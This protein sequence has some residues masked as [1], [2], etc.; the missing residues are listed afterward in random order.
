MM[1]LANEVVVVPNE[2]PV[3]VESSNDARPLNEQNG[4]DA[5]KNTTAAAQEQPSVGQGEG[6]GGEPLEQDKD[7]AASN[8]LLSIQA[9]IREAR[10]RVE[11]TATELVGAVSTQ[12]II[13]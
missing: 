1:E 13:R 9:K 12:V 3:V 5:T 7:S 11:S 10:E 2:K 8:P 4:N 6:K